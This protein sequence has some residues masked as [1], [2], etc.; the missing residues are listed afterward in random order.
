MVI[1]AMRVAIPDN[2]IDNGV[3]MFLLAF[4]SVIK[5]IF[6]GNIKRLVELVRW[7][8]TLEILLMFFELKIRYSLYDHL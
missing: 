8:D 4:S 1:P 2:N 5:S 7:M 3:S 6:Y